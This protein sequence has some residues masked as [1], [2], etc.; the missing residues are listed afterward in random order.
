MARRAAPVGAEILM[1][2]WPLHPPHLYRAALDGWQLDRVVDGL[3][4]LPCFPHPLTAMGADLRLGDDHLVGVEVQGAS[5]TGTLDPGLTTRPLRGAG[6]G[7]SCA[8]ARAAPWN[9]GRP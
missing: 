8:F 2:Q 6:G 1:R 3:E 7:K 5:P 4:R 9:S